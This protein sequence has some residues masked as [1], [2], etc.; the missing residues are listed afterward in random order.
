MPRHD[1]IGASLKGDLGNQAV[2]G[3]SGGFGKAGGRFGTI[4]PAGNVGDA[5]F[6]AEHGDLARLI[7]G[8]RSQRMVDR[9]GGKPQAVL[10]HSRRCLMQCQQQAG[11]ITAA[12]DCDEDMGGVL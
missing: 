7:G 4:P 6:G 9:D 2:A 12:G 8:F 11:G 3:K 1:K 5:K 10:T